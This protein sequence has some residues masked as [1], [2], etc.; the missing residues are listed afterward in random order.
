MLGDIRLQKNKFEPGHDLA[1]NVAKLEQRLVLNSSWKFPP[2]FVGALP[3]QRGNLIL[4][5]R[6]YGDAQR[7]VDKAFANF[8]GSLAKVQNQLNTGRINLAQANTIIGSNL[9]TANY[10]PNSLLGRLEA[11]LRAAEAKIPFGRGVSV[12][13]G[14]PGAL[15]VG[16]SDFSSVNAANLDSLA[17]WGNF[18][19]AGNSAGVPTYL[20]FQLA[21]AYAA[22][23]TPTS[24]IRALVE[25]TRQYSLRFNAT[26]AEPVF[27]WMT[28]PLGVGAQFNGT[29]PGYLLQ[30]GTAGGGAGFFGTRNT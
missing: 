3:G 16:L 10:A 28:A 11:S 13:I 8:A 23:G 9:A 4:T 25:W 19:A 2:G 17:A 30:Y 14:A 12:P 27:A 7:M 24:E 29:M 6:A 15:G 22:P 5:S 18:D 26:S 1:T 20:R 21:D